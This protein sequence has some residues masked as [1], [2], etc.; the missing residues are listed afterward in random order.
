MTV[1]LIFIQCMPWLLAHLNNDKMHVLPLLDGCS[2]IRYVG[3]IRFVFIDELHRS[4]QYAS[5]RSLWIGG[6]GFHIMWL[7]WLGLLS[8]QLEQDWNSVHFF[9]GLLF[10]SVVQW[11]GLT[12]EI[13]GSNRTDCH[14][15]DSLKGSWACWWNLKQLGLS[16]KQKVSS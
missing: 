9:K 6:A 16:C 13:A 12:L 3:V 5:E 7:V 15:I 2:N 10:W 1:G 11:A 4:I 8:V 14:S